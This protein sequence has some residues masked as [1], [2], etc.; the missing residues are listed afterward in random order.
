MGRAVPGQILSRDGWLPRA[1]ALA[2]WNDSWSGRNN[3]R[4][5]KLISWIADKINTDPAWQEVHETTRGGVR[6]WTGI[7]LRSAD[8]AQGVH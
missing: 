2:S 5:T 3:K 6:G 7:S 8:G 1:A 4:A